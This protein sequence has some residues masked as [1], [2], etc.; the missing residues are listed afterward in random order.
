MQVQRVE[1][2]RGQVR[3]VKNAERRAAA[4]AFC[5]RD[6]NHCAVLSAKIR[7]PAVAHHHPPSTQ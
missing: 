5:G 4:A 2:L 7:R 3:L 1:A 6:T